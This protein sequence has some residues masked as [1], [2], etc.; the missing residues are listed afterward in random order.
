MSGQVKTIARILQAAGSAIQANGNLVLLN[1]ENGH[2]VERIFDG[3]ELKDQRLVVDGV[4]SGASAAFVVSDNHASHYFTPHALIL[5]ITDGGELRASEFDPD[6]EEWDDSELNGL[7]KI[8]VQEQSGLSA[9]T[10]NESILVFYQ[11]PD[12]TIKSIRHDQGTKTW[13]AG[14]SVPGAAETGTPIAAFNNKEALIVAFVEQDGTIHAHSRDFAS[15]NWSETILPNSSFDDKIANLS[16][17]Q[18]ITSGELDSY[19]LIAQ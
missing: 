13:K 19:V 3:E 9:V 17:S 4:K 18:D 5:Y 7:D 16:V 1:V 2:L 10:I 8:K 12:G 11:A 15:G 14:F 6:S